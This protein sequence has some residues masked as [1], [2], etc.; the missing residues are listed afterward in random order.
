MHEGAETPRTGVPAAGELVQPVQISRLL[1]ELQL[2]VADFNCDA[3]VQMFDH[4]G[5]GALTFNDFCRMAQQ[6]ELATFLDA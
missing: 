1:T 4:G 6:V 5:K 3:M 2:D